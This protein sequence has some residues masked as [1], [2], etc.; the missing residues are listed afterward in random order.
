MSTRRRIRQ[1]IGGKEEVGAGQKLFDALKEAKGS[2]PKRHSYELSGDPDRA[3]A[4]SASYSKAACGRANLRAAGW[5]DD[6]FSKPVITVALPYSNGLP[7][8]NRVRE[9]G[10]IVADCIER[11]GGKSIFACTPEISDGETNGSTGM[12][13]S[14]P[15]RDLIA[16]SIDL[17]HHGYMAD[18]IICLSG[19][20]KTVPGTLMPLPRS[21]LIGITLY[22]GSAQPGYHPTLRD[23]AGLDPGFVMEAIGAYGTGQIDI[24][25]L[26][27]IE[28]VSLP[29]S[30]TCSA[31][32]TA[33]TMSSAVEAMGM[34]LPGTASHPV[35]TP[36]DWTTTP[37]ISDDCERLS[38]QKV[39]DCE[40]AVKALMSMMKNGLHSR[41]IITRKALENAIAIVFALGGSTNAF[42]HILAIA[43]EAEILLTIEQMGEIGSRIPLLG[44]LRPH[45]IYHMNDLDRVGGVPIVMKELLRAGF[46]HGECITC[47]GKTVAE[48][49]AAYPSLSDLSTQEVVR[50]ITRPIAPPGN[51]IIVIKG[52]LASESA[53]L[54]L[55]G[56]DVKRFV[57]PAIC[58]DGEQAAF[59]AI[60]GG[61]IEPG[62]ALIIRYEGPKGSPGMPEMLSPSAAL[63]GAGLGRDVALVTD[64]RFSGATHGI[65]IGH[66]SP[67]AAVGGPLA[68]V[69]DGDIVVIDVE[70]RTVDLRV[71]A[72]EMARR[73]ENWIPPRLP[74][75][76]TRGVLAKYARTVSSAHFGAL[77]D[78]ST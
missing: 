18:G 15:S 52:N 54:K 69:R 25:E 3:E 56:K 78:G 22:A 8:N 44:N 33:N 17:M 61:R 37:D 24:E 34:S 77:T 31:M 72:D 70:A 73:S 23:G 20:D 7:C 51:H 29:G 45:G 71:S 27:K 64:G 65:M 35:V 57:A 21:N 48:N 38:P 16:D 10:D 32:F 60:V 67:E 43:H 58:F 39:N 66:C 11:Q 26:H 14:L 1:Y 28:C 76:K 40:E 5:V 75:T 6:D 30:G 53:L 46:I 59:R 36:V 41:D 55:S 42:L 19:C 49:L 12:K 13:Y 62:S 68:L 74:L 63:I 9:L 50:P 2:T 4:E 47:T